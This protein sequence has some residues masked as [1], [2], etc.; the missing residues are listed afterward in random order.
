M[1]I[2]QRAA[3]SS[4]VKTLGPVEDLVGVVAPAGRLEKEVEKE[5]KRQSE[6]EE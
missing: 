3:Y 5:E 1:E 2:P 6:A 4:K